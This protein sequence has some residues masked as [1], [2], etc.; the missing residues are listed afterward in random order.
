MLMC[1]DAVPEATAAI[2]WSREEWT[3]WR[4]WNRKQV[5]MTLSIA[6]L[7]CGLPVIWVNPF[8]LL[9]KSPE[10]TFS[11]TCHLRWQKKKNKQ[12]TSWVTFPW[13]LNKFQITL[14]GIERFSLSVPIYLSTPISSVFP[15]EFWYI[16]PLSCHV[17]SPFLHI[18]PL[19]NNLV[20]IAH[21]AMS[22]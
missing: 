17:G 20:L 10:L 15:S 9:V 18:L 4:G 14:R 13:I 5:K 3:R 12:K 22:F 16:T 8:C 21:L 2:L 7:S 11:V 6:C 19:A 1:E